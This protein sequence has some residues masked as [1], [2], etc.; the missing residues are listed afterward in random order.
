ME[1]THKIITDGVAE[2][3]Q[4]RQAENIAVAAVIQQAGDHLT[5][6]QSVGSTVFCR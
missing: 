6:L 2:F 3:R 4:E 1:M 5:S